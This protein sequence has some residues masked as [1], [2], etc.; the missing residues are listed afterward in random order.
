MTR[1]VYLH[2]S[3][4]SI[5][6][7]ITL[8][9][10]YLCPIGP[11]SKLHNTALASRLLFMQRPSGRRHPRVTTT[12]SGPHRSIPCLELIYFAGYFRSSPAASSNWAVSMLRPPYWVQHRHRQS[13][14]ARPPR[15][16]GPTSGVYK[17]RRGMSLDDNHSSS[18]SDSF[19]QDA[20]T[21]TISPTY[22]S[23]LFSARV[24]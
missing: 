14:T 12:S 19:R 16:R 20:R 6:S 21:Y 3:R 23:C 18:Y 2:R 8:I 13:W 4:R 17:R 9:H 7:Q 10:A 22:M 11:V 5:S 15:P 1:D 24:S